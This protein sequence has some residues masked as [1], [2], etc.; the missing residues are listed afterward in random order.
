MVEAGILAPGDGIELLDG[1]LFCKYDGRRRR[2]TVGEYYKMAEVGILGPDERVELQ[3][4]EIVIMPPMGDWHA[5]CTAD[6]AE[7][8]EET[9]GRRASKRVQ[10]PLRLNDTYAPEPDLMLL[11]RR[12]DSYRSGTPRPEDVLLLIEVADTTIG[13]DRRCKITAY[14]RAGIPELW[15]AVRAAQNVEVHSEPVEGVYTRVEI[16]GMDSSLTPAAFP[17]ITIPVIAVMYE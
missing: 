17:D 15:L 7:L 9:V 1:D 11:R 16:V 14:A 8:L 13:P 4:G 6:F 12:A 3:D 2:F 10:T 5:A